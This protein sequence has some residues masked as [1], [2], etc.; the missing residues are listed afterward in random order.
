MYV[1]YEDDKGHKDK[2]WIHIYTTHTTYTDTWQIFGPT[3]E[4]IAI[5]SVLTENVSIT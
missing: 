4:Y 2:I 1:Y 5:Q 3:I